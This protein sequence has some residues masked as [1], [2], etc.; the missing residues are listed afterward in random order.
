VD[1]LLKRRN[2]QRLLEQI[3]PV[4]ALDQVAA[5]DRC[6]CV[7]PG[8]GNVLRDD[9]RRGHTNQASATL[10]SIVM[11]TPHPRSTGSSQRITVRLA[12]IDAPDGP[13]APYGEQARSYLQSRF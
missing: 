8:W 5:L 12:C 7:H 3:E 13:Q 2:C 10:L 11:A 9:L 1:S 4:L 6:C